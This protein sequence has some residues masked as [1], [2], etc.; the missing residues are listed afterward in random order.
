[1]M[2]LEA[3]VQPSK[4]EEVKAALEE[5]QIQ[6]IVISEVLDQGGPSAQTATYRGAKYR[7][8]VQRVKIEMLLSSLQVDEVV[9]V[10]S[11]AARSTGRSDDGTIL[12]YEVAEAIRI[13]TGRR[14]QF[15]LSEFEAS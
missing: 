4:L 13:G 3:I 1:M 10:I 9:A 8:D 12:V 15:Q 11:R 14:V 2:K 6:G 7:I 5:L